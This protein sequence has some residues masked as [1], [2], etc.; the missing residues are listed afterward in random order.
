MTVV[1]QSRDALAFLGA[2][3]VD[4]RASGIQIESHQENLARFAMAGPRQSLPQQDAIIVHG[5][6]EYMP[7]RIGVSL[8]RVCRELLHEDGV[9]V[10]SALD[11]SPDRH[12]LDRLLAWPT[13]R[14]PEAMLTRM[15]SAAGMQLKERVD[16]PEPGL[17]LVAGPTPLPA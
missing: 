1:D 16:V 15:F 7:E 9:V 8:M 13:I 17:L 3:G 11:A 14:R 10:V 5:M 6:V 2:A 12:L 4:S